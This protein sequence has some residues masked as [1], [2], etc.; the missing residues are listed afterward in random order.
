MYQ[1]N[2]SCVYVKG[3]CNGAIYEFDT[4]K[5]YS[6]NGKACEIIDRYI[7]G[8]SFEN[9]EN[10]LSKLRG[11]KLISPNYHP[12][13]FDCEID[14]LTE[15]EVAWIEITETCNL[16]CIHCYEGNQHIGRADVLALEDWIN[17][18]DQ[19]E[20]LKTKRLIIIGG[21]PCCNSMVSDVV[22]YSAKKDMDVTLFTNGTLIDE[23]LFHEIIAKR[24]KV[25]MSIYGPNSTVHDSVTRTPGSFERLT[26][27]VKRLVEAGISVSAA[28]II[29]KENEQF[30]D[31][32]ISFCKS[33]GI[34][35]S[36]YDVIREVFGGTQSAHIPTDKR[37]LEKVYFTKPNYKANRK[38]FIN[39][40]NKNSCLYG[41]L[42]IK[43]NG[44][45]IPCVFERDYVYG[46]VKE[47]PI[48]DIIQSDSTKRMWYWDFSKVDECAECEY[49]FACRDCRPL[50]KS[51]CGRLN[52]KNPRC[53]YDV[54]QGEWAKL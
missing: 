36:R 49:R 7:L 52:T 2:D 46:N 32:T 19:L 38:Q 15:L 51:V 27:S 34:K 28:V 42:A 13:E 24:I 40:L 30:A 53:L 35:C 17:V 11:Q 31:E 26:R 29:M 45:V 22:S 21:E 9:D 39:N 20:K 6:V 8:S 33:I 43:E 23:R 50:G 41:K 3:K 1:I 47:N 16:R 4:G 10:Y 25:K 37:V 48:K 12:C 14:D 54:S 44:D 5:V 18:I